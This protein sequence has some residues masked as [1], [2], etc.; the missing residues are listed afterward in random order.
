MVTYTLRFITI[1]ILGL[2]VA[3]IAGCPPNNI[4]LGYDDAGA[5]DACASASDGGETAPDAC[6]LSSNL[7]GS[8][9][10]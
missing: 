8:P 10:P 6:D 7:D 9:T 2:L 3:L 1:A 5:A 4:D